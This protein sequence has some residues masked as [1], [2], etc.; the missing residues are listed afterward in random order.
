VV[1]LPSKIGSGNDR[2]FGEEGNEHL[3]GKLGNDRYEADRQRSHRRVAR[4]QGRLLHEGVAF[5][6]AASSNTS[7]A[8]VDV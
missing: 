8:R 4:E 7:S 1:Y 3:N 6:S 5:P 2:V